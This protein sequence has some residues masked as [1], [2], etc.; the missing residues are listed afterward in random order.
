MEK[1]RLTAV[2]T[3]IKPLV[4]GKYIARDGFDPNYVIT[5]NGV[6]VSR[7]RI[8]ATVVDK[9]ISETGKFASITLDD[10]TDT[11]RTKMF[12]MLSIFDG[13]EIGDIVDVIGKVKEYQGEIYLAPEIIKKTE[14]KN[15]EILR[16]AELKQLEKEWEKRRE[17]I[18]EYRNQASDMEELK[19]LL[20]ERFGVQPEEVESF[21]ASESVEEEEPRKDKEKIAELISKLDS[22]SGCDYSSL[23]TASGLPEETVDTIVNDLLEEG[24]CFEPRPGK[25]KKL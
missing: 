18:K 2:K 4:T 17:I 21:L 22:G 11:I 15:F 24:A 8:L 14:D 1:K 23:I 3:R 12:T 19:I 10:G 6:R 7:A 5:S 13:I 25:I 16:E 9:F 20:K